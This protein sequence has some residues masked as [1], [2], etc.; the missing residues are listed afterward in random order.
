M[1]VTFTQ[2]AAGTLNVQWLGS[3]SVSA[4]NPYLFAMDVPELGGNSNTSLYQTVFTNGTGYMATD[5]LNIKTIG[6]RAVLGPNPG[7][8][9]YWKS[10]QTHPTYLGTAQINNISEPLASSTG[11]VTAPSYT[12]NLANVG[13]VPSTSDVTKGSTLNPTGSIDGTSQG[14]IGLISHTRNAQ[15]GLEW[16][17]DAYS[18]IAT[19]H[20]YGQ[21][22]NAQAYSWCYW[23]KNADAYNFIYLPSAVLGC[24][25]QARGGQWWMGVNAAGQPA[26]IVAPNT[27]VVGYYPGTVGTHILSANTTAVTPAEAIARVPG[28][29]YSSPIFS[30]RSLSGS[31][32]SAFCV[33]AA[34]QMVVPSSGINQPG[35]LKLVNDVNC[36]GLGDYALPF[37]LDLTGAAAVNIGK[38]QATDENGIQNVCLGDGRSCYVGSYQ[39]SASVASVAAGSCTLVTVSMVSSI[40]APATLSGSKVVSASAASNPGL[41]VTLTSYVASGSTAGVNVCALTGASNAFTVNV[42]Q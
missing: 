9:G 17:G 6:A 42:V 16:E 4:T 20:I 25:A 38:A 33:G 24:D 31:D 18:P 3:P 37:S 11:V 30:M 34:W 29:N 23:A 39:G 12:A 1:T 41:G 27:V 7:T 15:G 32:S 14:W 35:V 8:L 2:Q 22:Q 36:H 21:T 40:G 13:V 26:E 19:G 10:D 28:V 5:G